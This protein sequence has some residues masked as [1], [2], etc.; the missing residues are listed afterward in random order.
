MPGCRW[1]ASSEFTWEEVSQ[2]GEIANLTVVHAQ[3]NAAF[4]V[5]YV[6]CVVDLECGARMLSRIVGAEMDEVDV[7]T[8]VEVV[9]EDVPA[10]DTS[11]PAFRPLPSAAGSD[12]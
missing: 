12:Q 5:P 7:G 4:D 9:W 8:R 6:L 10:A 2:R 3:F 11:I 1:C